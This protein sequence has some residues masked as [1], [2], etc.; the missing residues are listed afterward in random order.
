MRN[1]MV[2]VPTELPPG[3]HT[4]MACSKSPPEATP[5]CQRG[6]LQSPHRHRCLDPASMK[7]SVL[8][9]SRDRKIKS[10]PFL[11]LRVK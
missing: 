5:G 7:S 1:I 8:L 11:S 3:G 4:P 2:R 6:G 10:Q 9:F